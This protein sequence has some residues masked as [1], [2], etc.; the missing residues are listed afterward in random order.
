MKNGSTPIID[1]S[2]DELLDQSHVAKILR[3]TTKFLEA[4]R[5]RGG[6]PKFIRVGRLVR[7]HP[8][9]VRDWIESRRVS[10]TSEELT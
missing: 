3:T 8:H 4:R 5:V 1:S 2:Q 6:G 10:S 9:D 7:Y